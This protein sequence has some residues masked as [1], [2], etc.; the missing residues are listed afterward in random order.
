MALCRTTEDDV[1][2]SYKYSDVHAEAMS[3]STDRLEVELV[4]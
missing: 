4:E 3:E 2:T 1:E